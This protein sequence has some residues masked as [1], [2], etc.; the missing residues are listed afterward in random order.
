M[1]THQAGTDPVALL[2]HID[3]QLAA[4]SPEVV[5]PAADALMLS[6]LLHDLLDTPREGGAR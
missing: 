4:G 1:S 5:I 6:A 2:G 3:T